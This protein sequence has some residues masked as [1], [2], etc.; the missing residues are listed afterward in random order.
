[1]K[2]FAKFHVDHEQQKMTSN[3]PFHFL[4]LHYYLKLGMTVVVLVC[5][6]WSKQ[7]VSNVACELFFKLSFPKVEHAAHCS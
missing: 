1:M 2:L 7:E 4:Y 6:Q 5:G 3:Q